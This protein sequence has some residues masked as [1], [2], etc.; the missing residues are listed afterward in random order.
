M[1][2]PAPKLIVAAH[3]ADG[4][5][6]APRLLAPLEE[7]ILDSHRPEA[8]STVSLGSVPGRNPEYGAWRLAELEKGQLAARLGRMEIFTDPNRCILHSEDYRLQMTIRIPPGEGTLDFNT[9]WYPPDF[10]F[11]GAF[12][13]SLIAEGKGRARAF[14]SEYEWPKG[15]RCGGF[16][17][18]KPSV[19]LQELE[20]ADRFALYATPLGAYAGA[21]G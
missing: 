1:K 5:I 4:A 9:I 6:K 18:L 10:P 11:A 17:V 3:A 20:N 12:R 14:V 2:T 8:R 7:G 21:P 13:I 16:L 19:S 15:A